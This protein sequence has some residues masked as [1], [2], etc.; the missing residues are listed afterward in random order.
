[1]LLANAPQAKPS[2]D[3]IITAREAAGDF[4]PASL[5]YPLAMSTRRLLKNSFG[6][7]WQAERDTALDCWVAKILRNPKRRRCRRTPN[8]LLDHS[9]GVFQQPARPAAKPQRLE[10]LQAVPVF[11]PESRFYK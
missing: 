8:L 11:V 10:T 4:P 3:S 7:Q 1:M 2:L 5:L 9:R 6:V